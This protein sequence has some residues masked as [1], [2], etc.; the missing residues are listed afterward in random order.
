MKTHW[1]FLGSVSA[2][3]SFV[4]KV[5][6]AVV[7]LKIEVP[8]DRPSALTLGS[9]RWGSGVIFDAAGHVLTVSYAVLDASRIEA[10][11]RNGVLRIVVPKREAMKPRRIEV[12][13][14]EKLEH[15]S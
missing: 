3:P 7:G 6:P 15:K 5:E 1:Y 14:V 12:Q 11:Y 4:Q 10:S 2:L 13:A 8:R 9:E